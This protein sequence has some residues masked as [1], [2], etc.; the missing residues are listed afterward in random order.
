MQKL[1]R[2]KLD[3]AVGVAALAR[4]RMGKMQAS[5]LQL[6][7]SRRPGS[8]AV[9]AGRPAGIA[10]FICRRATALRSPMVLSPVKP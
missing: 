7:H 9:P 2:H 1:Q 6:Q 10:G 5:S 8:Q 4:Q 3:F